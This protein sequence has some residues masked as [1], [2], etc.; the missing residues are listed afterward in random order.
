M[1]V[2]LGDEAFAEKCR[3]KFV[4]AKAVFEEKLWNGSYF[5]YDS[6]S[7]SNSKSIQADQLAG[8]WY[9]AAS[10]L[11]DLFAEFKI[12]SALEK[13]YDFNVMEVRGGRMGAVNG[14]H[15]SGKVDETCMQSREIWTGV[16]Y[17]A[18]ATMIHAGM[19]EQAFATAEGI[20]IACWSE[21]GFG[22]ALSTNKSM[23]EAPN[24]DAM[25]RTRDTVNSLNDET[26]VKKKTAN[27]ARCFG[28]AVFHCS[29]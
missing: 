16:T 17:G 5:N 8:Q 20:F 13:V 19:K 28:N 23:L 6:G 29:C 7:S 14:M 9:T 26:G 21:E 3:G 4:K 24:I 12:R 15:P 22:W 11:P 27:K 25:D 1:A 2:Q 18:A 10:G